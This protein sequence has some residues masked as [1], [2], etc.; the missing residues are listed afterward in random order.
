MQATNCFRCP[1]RACLYFIF[2]PLMDFPSGI[3]THLSAH[4]PQH[5]LAAC[6]HS[7]LRVV[8]K[9]PVK[10]ASPF[11]GVACLLLILL[12]GML[13]KFAAWAPMCP[14]LELRDGAAHYAAF[15]MGL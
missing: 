11:S 1:C 13:V 9:A 5:Q 7:N 8:M 6:E 12:A 2:I 10:P 15:R 14:S 4:L 3:P